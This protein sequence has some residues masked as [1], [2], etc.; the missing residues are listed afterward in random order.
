MHFLR[1]ATT[2]L[3]TRIV[4]IPRALFGAASR[5]GLSFSELDFLCRLFDFNMDGTVRPEIEGLAENAG[6]NEKTY[7][8]AA[9]SLRAK[10]L[11]SKKQIRGADGRLSANSYDLSG[12][13]ESLASHCE[14]G[15]AGQL[16]LFSRSEEDLPE[17]GQSN[18]VRARF[19]VHGDAILSHGFF[20]VPRAMDSHLAGLGVDRYA[21]MVAKYLF[22]KADGDGKALV[23]VR[24]IT[25]NLPIGRTK[26]LEALAAL[27]AAGLLGISERS[28]L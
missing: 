24:E 25:S 8:R 7:R 22:S 4:P 21:A 1:E 11:I 3:K 6:A 13:Y 27:S 14:S 5:L 15:D 20:F 26:A 28:V 10:G 17:A 19:G 12:L 9:E 18:S 23:R 16:R 2:F